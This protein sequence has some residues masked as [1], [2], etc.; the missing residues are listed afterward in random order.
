MKLMQKAKDPKFWEQVRLD[1]AYAEMVEKIKGYYQSSFQTEIPVLKY[2]ARMRFYGDGDR[3]EFE[4]PYFRRR[5][6][7]AA[8][9]L[10]ALIYP[11][12]QHYLDEMQEIHKS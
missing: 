9:A 6:F 4:R 5:T 7:L 8:T 3:H 1:P 10:L 11:E 12:E 2:S